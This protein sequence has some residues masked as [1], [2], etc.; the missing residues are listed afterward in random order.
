[1]IVKVFTQGDGP[2]TRHALEMAERL[3]VDYQVE[4]HDVD[5]AETTSQLELYD[6]YSYPTFLVA[7]DNGS[8][9]EIWRG[10]TP[11]EGDIKMFLVSE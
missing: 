2:E 11:L 1:M 3:A 10:Q 4:L 5:D 6:I 9:I 7:R 8:Q